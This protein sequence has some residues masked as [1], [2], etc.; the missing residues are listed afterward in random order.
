MNTKRSDMT[1]GKNVYQ[2]AN[3]SVLF[4]V[5][6][7]FILPVSTVLL[8][9]YAV[10]KYALTF[11]LSLGLAWWATPHARNAA[12]RYNI[13]DAPDG[14]LK[15]H[16][17]PTPYLGGIVI[18]IS[19]LLTLSCTFGFNEK[20]LG[21]TLAGSVL[22]IIGLFDDMQA[23]TPGVK[24]LGQLIAILVLIKSGIRIELIALPEWLNIPLTVLWIAGVINAINILDIMD[25]LAT[26]V[27]F[28]L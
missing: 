18:Y 10:L 4:I 7:F 17:Q 14:R 22:V 26:G 27:A 6:T 2:H 21:I 9:T 28:Y 19:F 20:I 24:F 12:L 11:L 25:G 5:L 1:V 13:V 8:S 15:D 16:S 23:V 3:L